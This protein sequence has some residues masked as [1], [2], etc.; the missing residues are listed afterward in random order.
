MEYMKEK[1]GH[2]EIF[3]HTLKIAKGAVDN[4]DIKQSIGV[5][6][7]KENFSETEAA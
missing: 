4:N 2:V 6:N 1:Y 3:L 7:Q 5:S